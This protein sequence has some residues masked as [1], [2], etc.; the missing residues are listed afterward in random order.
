VKKV[1]SYY[2]E[3]EEQNYTIHSLIGSVSEISE[4]IRKKGKR[5][6]QVDYNLKLTSKEALQARQEDLPEDK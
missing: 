2:T 3:P 1:N 4:R 5:K 6:G